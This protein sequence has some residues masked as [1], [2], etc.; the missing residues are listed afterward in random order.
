MLFF[1]VTVSIIVPFY[2]DCRSF[3]YWTCDS[4]VRSSLVC[5]TGGRLWLFHCCVCTVLA[6]VGFSWNLLIVY[7]YAAITTFFQWRLVF[8]ALLLRLGFQKYLIIAA[9]LLL[10]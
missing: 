3:T 10:F 2:S 4:G 6:V 7:T 8:S 5:S 9:M 1:N